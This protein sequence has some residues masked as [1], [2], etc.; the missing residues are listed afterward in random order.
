MNFLYFRNFLSNCFNTQPPSGE[1]GD[2]YKANYQPHGYPAK[3]VAVKT[4]KVSSIASVGTAVKYVVLL[5][6]LSN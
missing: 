5:C 6:C 1:F 2:V 3:T 4:L